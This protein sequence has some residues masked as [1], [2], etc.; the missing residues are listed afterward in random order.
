MEH[1]AACEAIYEQLKKD[2]PLP[3][4]TPVYI[5]YRD[6]KIVRRRRSS[7]G[8]T[9]TYNRM[10]NVVHMNIA[11]KDKAPLDVRLERVAHEYW[12]AHQFLVQGMKG[13]LDYFSKFEEDARVFARKYVK[14]YLL[15]K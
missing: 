4:E 6:E 8:G 11:M 1:K 15:S 13:S 10:F 7:G 3:P 14:E 9:C 5:H 12:H 2:Y